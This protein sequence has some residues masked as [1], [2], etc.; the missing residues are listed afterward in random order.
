MFL[1][2]FCLEKYFE[3]IGC[4]PLAY[5]KAIFDMK[6]PALR[7]TGF[8]V[9]G[10]PSA[11]QKNHQLIDVP[12]NINHRVP[13]FRN[14]PVEFCENGE[15]CSCHIWIASARRSCSYYFTRPPAKVSGAML[16]AFEL[17][18][19]QSPYCTSGTV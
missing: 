12:G 5:I 17:V 8:F 3:A 14:G 15:L 18:T 4:V 11:W 1:I 2:C 9:H 19:W 16:P 7:R 6:A 10:A 13:L